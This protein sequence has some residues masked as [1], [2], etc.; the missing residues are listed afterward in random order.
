MELLGE[1]AI[2]LASMG[3]AWPPQVNEITLLNGGQQ[4]TIVRAIGCK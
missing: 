3:T 2:W 1:N 4:V